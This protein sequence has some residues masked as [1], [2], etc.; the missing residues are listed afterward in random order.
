MNLRDMNTK[1]VAF[2][3]VFAF[4]V[5]AYASP[6][7]SLYDVKFQVYS[8]QIDTSRVTEID[9]NTSIPLNVT[10]SCYQWRLTFKPFFE[11]ATVEETLAISAPAV[12]WGNA[13]NTDVSE[14]RKSAVSTVQIDSLSGVATNIWCVAPGDPKGLYRFTVKY[15]GIEVGNTEFHVGGIL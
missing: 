6:P 9:K 15:R 13:G 4:P 2:T 10:T 1:M 12:N 14:D 5:S 8:L 7:E 3:V 11:A